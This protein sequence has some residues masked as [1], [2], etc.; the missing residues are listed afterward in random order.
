[1]K[2]KVKKTTKK[3]RST[4]SDE[5]LI[6]DGEEGKKGRTATIDY[7]GFVRLWRDAASVSEVAETL[8]IKTTSASAIANRLRKGGVP[9]KR[10]PRKGAQPIDVKKL[11]RIAAGKD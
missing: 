11:S 5:E 6:L 9:L 1:M 7:E 10:F 3:T 4:P 8:G 2:K